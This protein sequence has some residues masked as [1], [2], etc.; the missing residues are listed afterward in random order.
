M[1][2]FSDSARFFFEN[3]ITEI[4]LDTLENHQARSAESNSPGSVLRT[5]NKKISQLVAMSW[6]P[7]GKEIGPILVGGDQDKI[8]NLFL[9]KGILGPEDATLTRFDVCPNP[10]AHEGE[11][12]LK[13][14]GRIVEDPD[15]ATPESWI[16]EIPYPPRPEQVKDEM[17]SDWV[18]SPPDSDPPDASGIS[19][20]IPYTC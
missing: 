15:T 4:S 13:Y 2:E 20:W 1:S 19:L 10:V 18:N 11:S 6:L 16:F 17:L 8:R 12:N 5:L 14:T 3:G 9:E 7:D